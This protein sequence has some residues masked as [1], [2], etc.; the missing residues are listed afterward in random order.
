MFDL[1]EAQ[2]FLGAGDFSVGSL[3]KFGS[4]EVLR[5]DIFVHLELGMG[6]VD[7][8]GRAWSQRMML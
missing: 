7:A 8:V 2:N 6:S 3:D 5:A 1:A 4:C